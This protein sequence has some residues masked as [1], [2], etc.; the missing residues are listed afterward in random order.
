MERIKAG[1]FCASVQAVSVLMCRRLNILSDGHLIDMQISPA[2]C[3]PA[4]KAGSVWGYLLSESAF[5]ASNL[6]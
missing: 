3:M 1:G 5:S 6:V 2:M 4:V